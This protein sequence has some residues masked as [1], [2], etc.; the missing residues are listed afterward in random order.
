SLAG[1]REGGRGG[2]LCPRPHQ[3][4]SDPDSLRQRF[5]AGERRHGPGWRHLLGAAAGG[6]WGEADQPRLIAGADGHRRADGGSRRNQ[7]ERHILS[8]RGRYAVCRGPAS[9]APKERI[10]RP[11]NTLHSPQI[12]KTDNGPDRAPGGISSGWISSGFFASAWVS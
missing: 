5:E 10:G 6:G 11:R 8:C 2:A 1:F 9:D 4:R 7:T 12:A 3:S